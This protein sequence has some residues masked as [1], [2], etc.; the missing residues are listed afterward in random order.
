M[1]VNS[2]SE[3]PE[4]AQKQLREKLALS[5][6]IPTKQVHTLHPSPSEKAF[7][8][9]VLDL[10]GLH[11]WLCYHTYDSRR[12]SPG[13]PDLVMV[14]NKTLLFAELKTE[15]GKLSTHQAHWLEAL[16]KVEKISSHVWK[17]SDWQRLERMLR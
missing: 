12:S 7:M 10:A 5:P 17:P 15:K 8:Q 9:T 13:F 4:W 2:L 6:S 16:S 3:L 14:R 11:D 1:H